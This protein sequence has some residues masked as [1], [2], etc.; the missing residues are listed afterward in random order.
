MAYPR[1][2]AWAVG[3]AGQAA[4]KTPPPEEQDE[5]EQVDPA[6]AAAIESLR[7]VQLGTNRRASGV[8]SLLVRKKTPL[9]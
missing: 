1:K 5:A 9:P 7:S 6:V 8:H 2:D 3:N 4:V